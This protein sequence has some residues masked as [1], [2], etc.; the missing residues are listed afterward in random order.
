M[1]RSSPSV[2]RTIAVLNFFVEHPGQAFTFTDIVKA[3]KLGR[4]TCHALLAGLVE[5]QYL[6]RN[7]DKTYVIGP[8]LVAI[9]R[10][11]RQQFSPLQAAEP[12]IRA[13]ADQ[14]HAICSVIA[15]EKEYA[16][17]KAKAGA[18]SDLGWSMLQQ[19][20][21]PLRAS[22]GAVFFAWSEEG[23]IERWLDR[24]D[25]PASREQRELMY[26]VIAFTRKHGFAFGVRNEASRR[27]TPAGSPNET[28]FP[29]S[30]MLEIR[31]NKRYQV[32]YVIAPVFDA[33]GQ[34]AFVLNLS[35]LAG[36]VSG[37]KVAEMGQAL[38]E[39]SGRISAFIAG[40]DTDHL[41]DQD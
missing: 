7:R 11:A 8:A 2:M 22:A 34:V 30:L 10:V 25:S 29:I 26:K 12:E 33:A 13:L 9:G 23:E 6:Y 18:M 37:A 17:V 20:R 36:V 5:A 28:D 41:F 27:V 19:P 15:L 16:V 38:V 39:A 4:A 40:A 3:L 35:G 32:A 1:S 21:I 24:L 14:Y 31:K